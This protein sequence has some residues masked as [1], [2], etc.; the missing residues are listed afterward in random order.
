MSGRLGNWRVDID[1]GTGGASGHMHLPRAL[2]NRMGTCEHIGLL[3]SD[4]SPK[5]SLLSLICNIT[6]LAAAVAL[7][8]AYDED[9]KAY[10]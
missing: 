9:E 10:G 6:T 1:T 2:L 8:F 7:L 3:D 5:I 4:S